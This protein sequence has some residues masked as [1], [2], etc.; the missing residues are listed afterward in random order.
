[1]HLFIQVTVGPKDGVPAPVAGTPDQVVTHL[2]WA[3][4]Y[5]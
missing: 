1:M 5:R 3:R 4:M 2:D